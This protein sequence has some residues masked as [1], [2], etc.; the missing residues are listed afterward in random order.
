MKHAIYIITAILMVG[1]VTGYVGRYGDVI[2]SQSEGT[3]FYRTNEP[4]LTADKAYWAI[5]DVVPAGCTITDVS[6]NIANGGCSLIDNEIRIIGHT[7]ISGYDMVNELAVTVEGYGQCQFAHLS[8]TGMAV[9]GYYDE[10]N[11]RSYPGMSEKII[12]TMTLT[13]ADPPA[14]LGD[15]NKDLVVDWDEVNSAIANWLNGPISWTDVNEII[16]KWLNGC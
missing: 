15:T 3:I 16:S 12:N 8:D 11:S 5:Q 4:Y 10:A 6:C 14:C 9:Y 2:S 13:L 7:S 1:L